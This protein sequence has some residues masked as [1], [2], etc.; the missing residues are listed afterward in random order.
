MGGFFKS[1]FGQA[2]DPKRDIAITVS[3]DGAEYP[4]TMEAAR[5]DATVEQKI[6]AHVRKIAGFYRE[7]SKVYAD[8]PNIKNLLIKKINP[9][10]HQNTCPY[11]GVVHPFKATRARQCPDCHEKM[12]VRGGIYLK[13]E[14][15]DKLQKLEASYYEKTSEL[16]KL[17]NTIQNIQD[18]K[19]NRRYI[20]S[21]LAIAEAYQSCALVHNKSY[22]DGFTAWDFSW[23]T[24]NEVVEV[25]AATS[26]RP[27]DIRVNGYTDI[28]FAR[29]MH[30]MR[31]LKVVAT[32]KA[33]RK[34]ATLAIGCFYD[35]LTELYAHGLG[36]WR[37]D[38]ALRLIHVAM[39]LGNLTEHDLGDIE[40]SSFAGKEGE[41]AT[42][43]MQAAVVKVREYVLAES[44]PE[45]LKWMIY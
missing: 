45:R 21:Y 34:Y 13:Q 26:A 44:D 6:G 12:V 24:L 36:D 3:V 2:G 17:T 18:H 16:S 31:E 23:G 39:A 11:C 14:E 25:M 1:L 33:K 37:V 43:G 20:D 8:N 22:E 27:T 28:L 41:N 35:Y 15:V 19:N 9:H 42:K 10:A 5:V 7:Y 32:V 30:C 40:S 4:L 38:D 29:G